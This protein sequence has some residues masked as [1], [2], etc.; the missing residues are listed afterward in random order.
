V[1]DQ[2][3][4]DIDTSF[5]QYVVGIQREWM[6]AVNRRLVSILFRKALNLTAKVAAQQIQIQHYKAREW[7]WRKSGA[8]G[9]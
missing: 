4:S 7:L 1:N 8:L 5:K 6:D 9:A 3:L 2:S